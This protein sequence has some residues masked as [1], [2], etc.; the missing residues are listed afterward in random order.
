MITTIKTL[1]DYDCF[2]NSLFNFIWVQKYE[3]ILIIILI[4]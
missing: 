3:E 1:Y 4:S 2:L